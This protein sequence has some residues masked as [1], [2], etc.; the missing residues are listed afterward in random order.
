MLELYD[1]PPYFQ[2][3]LTPINHPISKVMLINQV[4][5]DFILRINY[6]T[7]TLLAIKEYLLKNLDKGFI[8]PSLIFFAL[9]IL[10]T[11]KLDRL[12]C[13]YINYYKL[14]Q[15]IKRD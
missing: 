7:L 3:L 11:K 6:L 8:I 10:F 12:L 14:N 9:L 15:I 4:L 5:I 13:F 1:S 2:H